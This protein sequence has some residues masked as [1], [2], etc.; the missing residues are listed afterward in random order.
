LGPGLVVT[1]GRGH[2][3][4]HHSLVLISSK[5]RAADWKIVIHL[6]RPG[7]GIPAFLL[8]Q[9][10]W[11]GKPPAC[12]FQAQAASRV[13]GQETIRPAPDSDIEETA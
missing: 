10:T 4:D 2:S 1:V 5:G 11:G 6:S 8:C 3:V 9:K 7:P 12:T 13:T